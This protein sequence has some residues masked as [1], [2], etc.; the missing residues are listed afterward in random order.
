MCASLS[1]L[2]LPK[3]TSTTFGRTYSK[4][5]NRLEESTSPRSEGLWFKLWKTLLSTMALFSPKTYGSS[6][7]RT[8]WSLCSSILQRPSKRALMLSSKASNK[9]IRKRVMRLGINRYLKSKWF[10]PQLSEVPH[11]S[12]ALTNY[13]NR[14]KERKWPSMTRQW[15]KL[16]KKTTTSPTLKLVSNSSQQFTDL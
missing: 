13:H 5:C 7:S 10:Q 9:T 2:R 12:Q 14:H 3:W 15:W 6:S 16:W 11:K 8:F 1:H 4:E